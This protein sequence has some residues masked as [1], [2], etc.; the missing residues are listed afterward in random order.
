MLGVS[1]PFKWLLSGE[2]ELGERADVLSALRERGVKSIE[3]RTVR[4]YH[5]ATQAYAAAKMLWDMGFWITVH[6]QAKSLPSAIQDVFAPLEELLAALPQPSL[7]IVLHPIDG[8]NAAVLR[9]LS[10]YAEQ[11]GY[12]V[13]FALENNRLLPSG[14]EGDCAALVLDAVKR[15]ERENVGICFDMGHYMYYVKRN[16]LHAPDTRPSKEFFKHVIHTHIHALNGLVT[17]FPLDT[18]ELPLR[19]LL[20]AVT[21]EYFGIYNLELDLPRIS[22]VRDPRDAL[23]GS[24]E[25][26]KKALPDPQAR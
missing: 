5:T 17:H 24:L 14:K 18:H 15:A 1:L 23:Y 10:T 11:Q 7:T 26:L 21:Y 4:P 16:C 8:D 3:L 19:E 25:Y 22:D 12:P 2:G 9:A 13:R 20:D 6:G